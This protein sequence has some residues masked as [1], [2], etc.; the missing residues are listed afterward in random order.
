MKIAKKKLENLIKET[1]QEVLNEQ[2][3]ISRGIGKLA[4]NRLK[5]K[6]KAK[7]PPVKAAASSG[8]NQRF[9]KAVSKDNMVMGNY[10]APGDR[11][12]PMRYDSFINQYKSVLAKRANEIANLPPNK[13]L[14][15]RDGNDTLYLT[16]QMDGKIKVSGQY[17][18]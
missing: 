14:V 13:Q 5:G 3:K 12:S 17:N 6:L 10:T 4:K 9:E 8:I 15:V 18:L 1:L 11:V 2:L 7:K 16:R